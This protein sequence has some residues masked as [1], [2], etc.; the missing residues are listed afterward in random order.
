MITGR[1]I[2]IK[3]DRV[4][5]FWFC[6]I[7]G[8]ALCILWGFCACA[9]KKVLVPPPKKQQ[10]Q[11]LKKDA[12]NAWQ[13]QDYDRVEQL[14]QRLVQSKRLTPQEEIQAWRRLAVASITNQH[15]GLTKRALQ[16]WTTRD[17][18]AS[19]HWDW[20]RLKALMYKYQGRMNDFVSF[21]MEAVKRQDS[22]WTLRLKASKFLTSYWLSQEAYPKAWSAQEMLFEKARTQ[23]Q[24][25]Q[26][27]HEF[28]NM[29]DAVEPSRWSKISGSY[30]SEDIPRFPYVLIEWQSILHSFSEQEISWPETWQALQG[31]L[32]RVRPALQRFLD[33]QFQQ[34]VEQYGA[35][36]NDIAVILPLTGRYVDMGWK[37][38]RG[39]EIAHWNFRHQ[40]IPLRV[41]LINSASDSWTR[42]LE[43]L[44]DHC[45]LVGGPLQK[46]TWQEIYDRNLYKERTFFAFCSRLQPGQEGQDGYRFFPSRRDQVRPLIETMIVEF[47]I[48]DFAIMYPQGS[49]GRRMCHVFQEE[50]TRAKA[51]LKAI[52]SYDSKNPSEWKDRV[53]DFLDVPKEYFEQDSGNG[54]DKYRPQP[55]FQA[56][57][58]PDSFENAQIMIPEFFFFDV[59]SLVFLGPALWSQQ[60][61][62]VSKLDRQYF[63]LSILTGMW[64]PDEDNPA[65]Q[66]LSKGLMETVQG[67]ANF[68]VG[69]GYDFLRWAVALIDHDFQNMAIHDRC[70]LLGTLSSEF[71][72]TIAPLNWDA[73]GR[74][75]QELF[76]L[77]P[78]KDGVVRADLPR[79]R[80]LFFKRQSR[81]ASKG[82]VVS[83]GND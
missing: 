58:L 49:Y 21:L 30:S 75:S 74:A 5:K 1:Q 9:P 64:W 45:T 77:Q 8:G 46:S 7:I 27:F 57:F 52:T 47:G 69:L 17:P 28:L 56:L 15:F 41:H 68:W 42:S 63:D 26:V 14:Y 50:L 79:I 73:K 51:D 20:Y 78:G 59:D 66:E 44:P 12:R 38:F 2:M 36:E 33:R 19:S 24:N 54:T 29:L 35:I 72:W 83:S 40:G 4:G 55:P 82:R 62:N 70:H 71:E 34:L 65:F 31:I 23:E 67:P 32:Q 80:S 60:I 37:I 6:L 13:Q 3:K 25:N 10:L 61:R 81:D 43:E 76:V 39:I 48:S 22:P 16:Q 11:Q 53:A 18:T